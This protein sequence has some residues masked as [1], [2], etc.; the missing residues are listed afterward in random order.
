[1]EARMNLRLL[2]AIVAAL[3]L[4]PVVANAGAPV[5]EPCLEPM[6]VLHL[7]SDG[8]PVR[9]ES[10]LCAAH[11]ELNLFPAF[12]FEHGQ[13]PPTARFT[14]GA[15][16][17]TVTLALPGQAPATVRLVPNQAERVAGE[18]PPGQ[19]LRLRLEQK[20]WPA[21]PFLRWLSVT[22]IAVPVRDL[23]EQSVRAAGLRIEGSE[24]LCV[25]PVTFRFR[26]GVSL[27]A[28]LAI[29]TETC[30]ARWER[31]QADV[32]RIDPASDLPLRE[33]PAPAQDDVLAEAQAALAADASEQARAAALA[34]AAARLAAIDP[35][36]IGPSWLQLAELEASTAQAA[37]RVDAL[38][39][40]IDLQ[41]RLPPTSDAERAGYDH[42]LGGLLADRA[43]ALLAQGRRAEA[44]ADLEHALGLLAFEPGLL[45]RA[46]G[47][48]D[49]GHASAWWRQQV[50]RVEAAQQAWFDGRGPEHRHV[51]EARHRAILGRA[52]R[53]IATEAVL[54]GRLK[55]AGDAW[56]EVAIARATDLGGGHRRTRDAHYE[57]T[58]LLQLSIDPPARYPAT[59]PI[60]DPPLAAD[61]QPAAAAAA[62][63]AGFD[64]T[65]L[66]DPALA[67]RIAQAL[68]A[69]TDPDAR[70]RLAVL[71]AEVALLRDGESALAAALGHYRSATEACAAGQ[72]REG[73]FTRALLLQRIA[74]L[75]QRATDAD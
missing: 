54:A 35:D 50:E 66:F 7:R 9:D 68:A 34:A 24:H 25:E 41:M 32:I 53:A 28:L 33:P 64:E 14:V 22:A 56:M 30:A 15:D 26:L 1:M 6:T 37:E 71:A 8:L 36:R 69:A 2:P 75:D 49:E 5:I 73:S 16:A 52:A 42:R 12:D 31:S 60:L 21:D 44:L 45:D 39:R 23:V 70:A 74:F 4:A 17:A 57:A 20:P 59:A 65:D 67:Q 38:A 47:L 18:L 3:A 61:R 58:L 40:A 11:G 51:D 46:A 43:D 48:V 10:I 72:C 63:G 27:G 55:D 13:V 62:Q 29:A 19:P